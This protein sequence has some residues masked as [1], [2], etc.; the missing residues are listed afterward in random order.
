MSE[1]ELLSRTEKKLKFLGA[2]G[3]HLVLYSVRN[4][5]SAIAKVL[6]HLLA[7]GEKN[8]RENNCIYVSLNKECDLIR[9][10]F[11]KGSIAASQLYFIE[12]SS[13]PKEQTC[14]D[15]WH[16]SSPYALTEL[17]LAINTLLSSG[18][19]K[20]LIFDSL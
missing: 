10:K 20:F 18:K 8:N 9:K 6:A 16:V 13:H 5:D 3:A 19:S 1:L 14:K 11:I 15:C 7:L 17:S 2:P 12:I 4:R